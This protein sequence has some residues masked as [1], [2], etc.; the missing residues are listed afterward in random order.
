MTKFV[1]I[2]LS[3]NSK[4]FLSFKV[5][6]LSLRLVAKRV[7]RV[8]NRTKPTERMRVSEKMAPAVEWVVESFMLR[9]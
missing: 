3:E 8:V 6:K 9:E 4:K 2:R 7:A 5:G 1:L